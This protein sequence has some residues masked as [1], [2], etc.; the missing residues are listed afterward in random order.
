MYKYEFVC[1]VSFV[2]IIIIYN[3]KYVPMSI[4]V[5][6]ISLNVKSF[7]KFFDH[8]IPV[9]NLGCLFMI[10][11]ICMWN[12]RINF[13]CKPRYILLLFP[14]LSKFFFSPPSI[15]HL[16]LLVSL[17]KSKLNN[18]FSDNYKVHQYHDSYISRR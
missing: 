6:F 17:L 16:V 3:Q 8:I 5:Y 1:K 7:Q 13:L 12:I 4:D 14:T 10:T 9:T 2:L 15:Y 11:V 18:Y